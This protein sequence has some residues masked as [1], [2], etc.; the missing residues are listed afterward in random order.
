MT[1]NGG[2]LGGSRPGE[3]GLREKAGA[4]GPI[5]ARPR[6]PALGGPMAVRGVFAIAFGFFAFSGAWISATGLA[7]G[8]TLYAVV[9]AAAA[10]VAGSRV[11]SRSLVLVAVVNLLTGFLLVLPGGLGDLE[12][13]HLVG[14]W[15]MLT[16]IL[17]VFAAGAMRRLPGIEWIQASAGGMSILLGIALGALSGFTTSGLA[18]SLGAMSVLFGVLCIAAAARATR[19]L[20]FPKRDHRGSIRRAARIRVST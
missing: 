6:R 3:R 15:A 16:G 20:P 2:R 9:A 19:L 13:P 7:R 4:A 10:L 11:R 14:A 8:F 5:L 12:L 1:A 17:E 18:G